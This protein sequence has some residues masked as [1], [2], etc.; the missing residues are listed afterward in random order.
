MLVSYVVGAGGYANRV[1]VLSSSGV[2]VWNA[3]LGY[4]NQYADVAVDED[5]NRVVFGS[6][7]SDSGGGAG[8]ILGLDRTT[9]TWCMACGTLR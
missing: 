1:Q 6:S 5:N 4:G 2:Q 3:T 9:G 8:T 7:G